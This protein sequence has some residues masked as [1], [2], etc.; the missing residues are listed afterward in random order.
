M[1]TFKVGEILVHIPDPQETHFD[2]FFDYANQD[3]KVIGCE[4]HYAVRFATHKG[5]D[6]G[7]LVEFKDGVKAVCKAHELRRKSP[8]AS[9]A[10]EREY[11]ALMDRL[12]NRKEQTA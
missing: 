7:Y 3:C 2:I 4:M 8:P 11:E 6:I 1:G 10:D 12:L 9:T 5:L